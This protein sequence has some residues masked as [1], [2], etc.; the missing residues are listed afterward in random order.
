MAKKRRGEA[1]REAS[2][3]QAPVVRIS[4][5]PGDVADERKIARELIEGELQKHP[6]YS[7]LK[8]EVIAWDDPAARI[9]MPANETPQ[10]LVNDARPRPSAC[11]I[12]IVI[13]WARM[14]HRCR[15]KSASGAA[16]HTCRAR[17]GSTWTPS[18]RPRSQARGAGLSANR[19]SRR[20]GLRDPQKKEKEEQ[21]ELVRSVLRP[22]SQH[23]WEA[24]DLCLAKNYTVS[25][26]LK[27]AFRDVALA[28]IEDEVSLPARHALGLTLGRVGDPR[29]FDLRDSQDNVDL[30]AYAEVPVGTYPYG[31]EGRT[32]EIRQPFWIGRYPVTNQQFAAFIAAGGYDDQQWWSNEGW[33]LAGEAKSRRARVLARLALERTEPA[34]GRGDLLGG[35]GVLRLGAV[36]GSRRKRNGKPPPAA[37]KALSIPGAMRGSAASAI[38][39]RPDLTSRRRWGCFP[40]RGRPTV[41]STIWLATSGSGAQVFYDPKSKDF[42]DARVLRGGSWSTTRTTRAQPTATGSTRTT[43]TTSSDF[44]W[45]VSPISG[46]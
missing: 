10:E 19:R 38:R 31:K 45:C 8:L 36:G 33:A 17:S 44:G 16:S 37:R 42:P 39:L 34:G 41:P 32:V 9:P 43:G 3:E 25:E 30:R 40:A 5:S 27:E 6:F 28:A 21:F 15:R 1:A 2:A 11:D 22:V 7:G 24:L 18:T 35:G 20:S 26:E 23:G 46:H 12:V 29:I 13:L 14:G 4:S